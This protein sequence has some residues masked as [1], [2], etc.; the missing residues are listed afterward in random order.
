MAERAL[1]KL[2]AER[3]QREEL[4][5]NI[6]NLE[7]RLRFTEETLIASSDLLSA[8]EKK[9]DDLKSAHGNM[10]SRCALLRQRTDLPVDRV[11]AYNALVKAQEEIAA[12]KAQLVNPV[13]LPAGY[14]TRNGHPFHEG[15]RNVMIP[16]KH[17]DWLSR[18]DVEHAIH[19]AGFKVEC[20]ETHQ[21]KPII[22]KEKLCDWLE[23][24][25]DIDDSQRDA[26]A[27][28]FA[29]HCNCI[30]KKED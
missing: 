28:C 10:V 7:I 1:D 29:H 20:G 17:G 13:V 5:K 15:E 4:G 19:V 16:N 23:D 27:N 8:A 6:A 24:N 12:M 14:S 11:P 18:F 3:Q 22:S 26:F 30:V 9:R 21:Q 2:E 25:F